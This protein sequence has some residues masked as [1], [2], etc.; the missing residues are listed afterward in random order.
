[1]VKAFNFKVERGS[2]VCKHSP[3]IKVCNYQRVKLEEIKYLGLYQY[4]AVPGG[5][6]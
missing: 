2:L 5:N 3:D 1:M 4:R 6:C